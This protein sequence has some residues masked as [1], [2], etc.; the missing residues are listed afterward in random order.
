[1]QEACHEFEESLDYSLRTIAVMKHHEQKQLGEERVIWFTLPYHSSSKE[2]R[3][4]TQTEQE[5][6]TKR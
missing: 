4:G 3:I 6:G 1:M 2:I 5:P